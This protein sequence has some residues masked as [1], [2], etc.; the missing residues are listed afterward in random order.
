MKNHHVAIFISSL[1]FITACSENKPA[2]V[3]TLVNPQME[4][5]EKAK[6]VE[7]ITQDA[8]QNRREQID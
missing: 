2:K 3:D 1:L 8:E 7:Q 4:A 6:G 5:L